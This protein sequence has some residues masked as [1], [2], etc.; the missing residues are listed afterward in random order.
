MGARVGR[1][2]DAVGDA[3]S[4]RRAL[5]AVVVLIAVAGLGTQAVLMGRSAGDSLTTPVHH[6]VRGFLQQ[7][8]RQMPAGARYAVTSPVRA[9]YAWYFLYPRPIVPIRFGLDA[10]RLRSQLAATRVRYVIAIGTGIPADLRGNH[11]WYTRILA[12]NGWS[13]LEVHP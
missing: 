1:V 4:L 6:D 8:D 5:A 3:T 12:M 10:D 13:L 9:L 2:A 11:R 7:V